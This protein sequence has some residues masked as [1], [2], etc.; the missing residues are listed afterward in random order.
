MIYLF[1]LTMMTAHYLSTNQLHYLL[2]NSTYQT[3]QVFIHK[4]D[5]TQCLLLLTT[6]WR[7]EGKLKTTWPFLYLINFDTML[8]CLQNIVALK[9]T[10]AWS[11]RPFYWYVCPT[12][13][14]TINKKCSRLWQSHSH[15]KFSTPVKVAGRRDNKCTIYLVSGAI[16]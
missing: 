2:P 5:C 3:V 1:P 16:I 4:I 8:K 15:S 6:L 14:T 7:E 11:L 12:S 13:L 9:K 10:S